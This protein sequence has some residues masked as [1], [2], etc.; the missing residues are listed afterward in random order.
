MKFD[1][2]VHTRYSED[3]EGSIKEY[4]KEAKRKGLSGFAVTDHNSTRALKEIREIKGLI[5]I[6]GIEVSTSRGH[7]IG[8]GI[9]EEIPRGLSPE[10]TAERISELGGIVIVPHPERIGSGLSF[11]EISEILG[12]IDGIE[13]F[14]ARSSK[15]KNLRALEYARERGIPGTGGSDAHSPRQLGYG[16]T[17]VKGEFSS[18]EEVLEE[19][20]KGNCL[21]TGSQLPFSEIFSLGIKNISLWIKRGMRK[22]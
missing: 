9:W 13:V 14:N 10:E 22:I 7:L 20:R 1:L 16:I 11:K 19:I 8:L 15:R 21:G 18:Y 4:S 6:P 2:H 17:E 3:G 5:L 12:K